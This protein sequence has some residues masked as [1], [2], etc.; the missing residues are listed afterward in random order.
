MTLVGREDRGG[1]DRYHL[2]AIAPAEQVEI[3]TARLVR[4]QDVEIDLWVQPVT[5]L[6]AAAEF[7][8]PTS[9]GDVTWTLELRDYGDDFDISRP[10]G[11]ID[12]PTEGANG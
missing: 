7:D 4:D 11:L 1:A 10:D 12:E 9:E 2:T 5:G 6:V 3:I 8:V